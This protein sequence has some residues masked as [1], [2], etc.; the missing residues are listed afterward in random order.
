MK[1]CDCV[2]GEPIERKRKP[3]E[4]NLFIKECMK[5]RT[6]PVQERFKLCVEEYKKSKSR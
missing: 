6:E 2:T 5:R 1:Y 3:S 4:Y